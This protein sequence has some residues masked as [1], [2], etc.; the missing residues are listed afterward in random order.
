MKAPASTNNG[1]KGKIP[2]PPVPSEAS[3]SNGRCTSKANDFSLFSIKKSEIDL[4]VLP[5]GNVD[6]LQDDSQDMNINQSDIELESQKAENNVLT[7]NG[8]CLENGLLMLKETKSDVNLK[9]ET[10]NGN[11]TENL[12]PFDTHISDTMNEFYDDD[13][14]GGDESLIVHGLES[15]NMDDRLRL[16]QQI[17]YLPHINRAT[18]VHYL[19][20][21]AVG[22]FIVSKIYSM[23]YKLILFDVL[24]Q[25]RY[26]NHRNHKRLLFLFAFPMDMVHISNIISSN[27]EIRP[28]QIV[29]FV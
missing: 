14:I 20:G 4:I 9:L 22:V 16:T 12:I 5:E 6:E 21:K 11:S 13:L 28:N 1:G 25:S 23:I 8:K 19:Q 2:A 27:G 3:N 24:S 17:W 29:Y 26:D 10:L 15:I 7:N 18:V